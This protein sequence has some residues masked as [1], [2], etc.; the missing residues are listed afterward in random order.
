MGGKSI[1]LTD[2]QVKKMFSLRSQGATLRS[3]GA[4]FGMADVTAGKVIN[5]Q[6]FPD[7]EID[8]AVL[9]KV[10]SLTPDRVCRKKRKPQK[11]KAT[12]VAGSLAAYTAACLD[13]HEAKRE[14]LKCGINEDTLELLR[15]SIKDGV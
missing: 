14:C 2:E 7:V 15:Q 11:K 4:Q 1:K 12:T 8:K 9:E 13:L 6:S 10:K 5:R 3:I